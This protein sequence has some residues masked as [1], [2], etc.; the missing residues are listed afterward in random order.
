MCGN[1]K[2]LIDSPKGHL[3]GRKMYTVKN[4]D[5]EDALRHYKTEK[6]EV[7]RCLIIPTGGEPMEGSTF[8]YCGDTKRL[9][10]LKTPP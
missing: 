1:Y 9:K 7:V 10:D 3:I 4:R 8:R 5:E 6:Y 2:A